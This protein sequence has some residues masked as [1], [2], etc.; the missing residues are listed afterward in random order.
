MKGFG[1][2][3]CRVSESGDAKVKKRVR[4]RWSGLLSGRR[5]SPE[6][7]GLDRSMRAVERS[8]VRPEFVLVRTN[9]KF[10][11]ARQ[12]K[13]LERLARAE[14]NVSWEVRLAER[15]RANLRFRRYLLIMF[16]RFM[17]LSEVRADESPFVFLRG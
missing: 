17:S 9:E 3:G 14:V 5:N 2:P 7:Q 1:F 12:I 13:V 4:M 15:E 10:P 16:S 6:R 8:S 11:K